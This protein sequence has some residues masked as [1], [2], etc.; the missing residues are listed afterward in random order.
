[1]MHHIIE[2]GT[3]EGASARLINILFLHQSDAHFIVTH[4]NIDWILVGF[5]YAQKRVL[6]GMMTH[7]FRPS[8]WKAEADKS[9]SLRLLWST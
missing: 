4:W 6:L 1:M 5:V 9:L 7:S 2:D 8:T 3:V